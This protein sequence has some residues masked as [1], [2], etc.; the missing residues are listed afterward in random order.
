MDA[1]VRA[2]PLTRWSTISPRRRCGSAMPP[3]HAA[4]G[5]RTI[6]RP[7]HCT[8]HGSPHSGRM[9]STACRSPV[10]LE[11]GAAV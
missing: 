5:K 9:P 1:P 3:G 6:D 8:Q 11:D 7:H 10:K 2:P 4:Q